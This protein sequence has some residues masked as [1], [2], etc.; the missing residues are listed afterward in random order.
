MEQSRPR[1]SQIERNKQFIVKSKRQWI[2]DLSVFLF[3]MIVW[4]YVLIVIYFFI[5]VILG[6]NHP[7][8]MYFK[9]LFK[10]TNDDVRWFLTMVLLAYGIIYVLLYSWSRYNKLKYG[11]L[12][13]RTYP[14]DTQDVDFI[15]LGMIDYESYT[16]LQ[17]AKDITLEKNPMK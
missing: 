9:T 8:P 5:D 14:V 16:K 12:K 4:G 2:R 15:K 6:L 3:S 1:I 7:I 17:N 10:T 13:R 11:P